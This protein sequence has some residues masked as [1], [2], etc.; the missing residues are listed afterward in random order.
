MGLIEKLNVS[1]GK[2][3]GV[4]GLT[5]LLHHVMCISMNPCMDTPPCLVTHST[6]LF[7]PLVALLFGTVQGGCSLSTL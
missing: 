5:C 1:F 4:C 6:P 3:P 7:P 2:C